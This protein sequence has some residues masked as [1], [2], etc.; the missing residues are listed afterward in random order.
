M[1]P[2]S[3]RSLL[4]RNVKR[5][6][7][8]ASTCS[9]LACGSQAPSETPT[10]SPMQV[11]RAPTPDRIAPEPIARPEKAAPES[12]TSSGEKELPFNC[13]APLKVIEEVSRFLVTAATHATT[14]SA[15]VDGPGWR[16]RIDEI[17]VCPGSREK[18]QRGFDVSY[19]VTQWTEGGRQG[20]GVDCSPDEPI[21]TYERVGLVFQIEDDTLTLEPLE[22]VPGLSPAATPPTEKHDGDCYGTSSPFEP[23]S[24]NLG[25]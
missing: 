7:L 13:Q 9:T 19:R 21:V 16:T 14:S 18:T 23:K 25:D 4:A 10:H 3:R 11:D 6:V 12:T 1:K 2:V 15:C 17:M 22:K 8:L 5:I 20:C 24:L